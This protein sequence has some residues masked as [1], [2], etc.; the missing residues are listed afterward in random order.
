MT[1]SHVLYSVVVNLGEVEDLII[2]IYTCLRPLVT[3]LRCL[4][5]DDKEDIR[6]F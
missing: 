6:I 1:S 5:A 4:F 3:F 2:N